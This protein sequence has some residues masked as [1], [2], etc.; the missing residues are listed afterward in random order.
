MRTLQE[1]SIDAAL[2]VHSFNMNKNAIQVARPENS[3][4]KDARSWKLRFGPI[5]AQA[6]RENGTHPWS[7]MSGDNPPPNLAGI[8]E[9]HFSVEQ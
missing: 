6:Q 1:P 5:F 9:H 2:T 8:F 7:T 4:R 3:I